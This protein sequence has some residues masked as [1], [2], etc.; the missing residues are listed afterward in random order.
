[1]DSMDRDIK[2]RAMAYFKAAKEADDSV[3]KFTRIRYD[4]E[5][6][7]SARKNAYEAMMSALVNL[8][9]LETLYKETVDEANNYLQEF[10]K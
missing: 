8:S 4:V 10:R 3:S 9:T 7:Y 1:M 5:I 2:Q 6:S